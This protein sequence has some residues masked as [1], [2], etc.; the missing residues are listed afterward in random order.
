MKT[1]VDKFLIEGV[2]YSRVV[3][4]ENTCVGCAFRYTD[5]VM[6]ADCRIG[7]TNYIFKRHYKVSRCK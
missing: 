2:L 1:K 4:K 3:H 5:C 6:L 7:D